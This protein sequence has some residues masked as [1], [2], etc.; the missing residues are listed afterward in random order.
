MYIVTFYSFKGGVGRTM[1]LVN[2][3][4]QLALSGKRVL[5]VDFDL[6]APGIPTFS[7]TAPKA[8]TPGLVEYICK[9]RKSGLAPK[10]N[11]F[12]YHAQDFDNGGAV[13]VMPAGLH[14]ETYSARF[15]SIDWVKLYDEESGYIFF[16]DL[17]A[18][19]EQELRPDYVLID[20]RT[21]HS[22]VEGIC[23]RQL[24]NA[25][26][27]L[28]F[29]N[30]QNLQGLKRVVA[31]IRSQNDRGAREQIYMHFAVSNVPDLDDE[32]G[33]IGKVL[34]QFKSELGYKNIAARI[35]HYNSL[36]LLSQEVFTLKRPNS[37][38]AK[39]YQTLVNSVISENFSDKDVAL[40][41]LRNASRSLRGQTLS[42][43]RKEVIDRVER[44]LKELPLDVD[45]I[46]EAAQIYETIGLVH[47]A[48]AL[49]PTSIEVSNARY[50][51]VRARLNDR[52]ARTDETRT[53]LCRMLASTDAEPMSFLQAL[54]IAGRKF[55]EL[56][57]SLPESAAFASLPLAD[58]EFIALQLDG[59]GPV[60]Q[61]KSQML[62]NL[63]SED[64][65][66]AIS[67]EW[68]MVKI[69]L[70]HF[71]EAIKLIQGS[72]SKADD[73]DIERTFN[74]AMAKLGRD[75]VADKTLFERVLLLASQASPREI[76][77]NYLACLAIAAYATGRKEEALQKLNDAKALLRARPKRE[78]SPWSY[79][80][81]SSADFIRHM[82]VLEDQI[83]KDELRPEFCS[84]C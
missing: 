19:W 68:G 44:A 43:G 69:G 20:S 79:S 37:R 31:N 36:S 29:P 6:E 78:F 38:L 25:V 47:D 62:A 18:Q 46:I 41:Y 9:Y 84:I 34:G 60:L 3:A 67:H 57:S 71:D 14:N 24:P 80:K 64:P 45:I 23:T 11:D 32:D 55:P 73:L 58:K 26:C 66:S 53:D 1:A 27:L 8:E 54:S 10:V 2:T 63:H 35:H 15:N 21:G 81:V 40:R 48:L 65:D 22:D 50:Y 17:R 76:D 13:M 5:I 12:V 75:G 52:T 49:M 74:L 33:I 39:E 61:A 83:S 42:A 28:F 59:G 30:D 72:S 70:G 82:E 4:A 56:V 51:A 7:L 16:E 77:S